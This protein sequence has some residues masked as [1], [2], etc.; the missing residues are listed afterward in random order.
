M[1]IKKVEVSHLE[2]TAAEWTAKNPVLRNHEEGF[3]TDTRQRKRGNGV[4][5]WN[6]LGY[7]AIQAATASS[8]GAESAA[9]NVKLASLA[10]GSWLDARA[11]EI[12]VAAPGTT[13]LIPV[14][15]RHM[16]RATGMTEAGATTPIPG[17]GVVFGS[18]F[19]FGALTPDYCVVNPT[20]DPW[21]VVFRAKLTVP[22]NGQYFM[23]GLGKDGNNYISVMDQYGAGGTSNT[24]MGIRQLKAA[25]A[26]HTYGTPG[27]TIDGVFH[28]YMLAGDTVAIKL[29]L[30]NALI[31][32]SALADGNTPTTNM[33][34]I[35]LAATAA[36]PVTDLAYAF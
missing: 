29:Y 6:S 16:V 21:A 18:T 36:I 2:G 32:S 1:S 10:P 15:L 31:A 26:T 23:L 20:T 28:N 19:G 12:A 27:H 7:V 9:N 8:P 22:V 24:Q 11:L 13:R 17:G 33:R 3:E 4:T 5:A 30:D 14:D 25:A 34:I 35:V